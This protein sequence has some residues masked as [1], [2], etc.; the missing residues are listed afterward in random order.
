MH[1]QLSDREIIS[2]STAERCLIARERPRRLPPAKHWLRYQFGQLMQAIR[3]SQDRLDE[4]LADFRAEI[5]H[6]QEEAAAKA[7]QRSRHE[8]PYTFRKKGHEEQYR[9]NSRLAETISEGQTELAS[10]GTSTGTAVE[11]AQKA[12]EKGL[13]LIRER[14]KLIRIADRSDL[15]WGVVA[16]Y[17]A[18]ELAEDSEDEKRLEKAE[19]AAERKALKRKRTKMVPSRP[20]PSA[21]NPGRSIGAGGGVGAGTAQPV[22]Q[23][24]RRTAATLGQQPTRPLGP[25][26]ACGEMGHLRHRCPHTAAAAA[27][28]RKWY[29]PPCMHS[30]CSSELHVDG[31]ADGNQFIPDKISIEAEVLKDHGIEIPDGPVIGD[32][33][34]ACPVIP[35]D[36]SGD[37]GDREEGAG[38]NLCVEF[39]QSWELEN[40]DPQSQPVPITVKGRLRESIQFWEEQLQAPDAV[41]NTIKSGYVLPLKSEPTPFRGNNHASAYANFG[42]VQQS[43]EELVASLCVLEVSD[44]PYI[45]SPLSVV[46]SST[47]KRRLVVNLRHL[48]R[49]LWKQHFKYEDLRVAILLFQKGDFMFSFDL[50]SGYH[51][52]DIADIHTKYLGFSWAGKYYVFTVLPFG[53]A[54]A[55]Y[56]FTKLLRPLTRFWRAK[57]LRILIY[58]DDGI[59]AVTGCQAAQ[60][61]S[62]LVQTTL[63]QAGFVAHPTKS[64]W[65]PVQR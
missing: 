15:G 40:Q 13:E 11:R 2:D 49:F 59:C 39:S 51:H 18:D 24:Q 37:G 8:K 52:V 22:V 58:L 27:A 5:R 14:Q 33:G 64:V 10:A 38:D 32:D 6:S 3:G 46:E 7:I 42:F 25:C 28:D 43:V 1:E 53:L 31:G 26:F 4:K 35:D 56:I 44:P 20:R 65:Q 36:G 62:Q 30:T 63:Q 23:M 17:T 16:E 29:P 45:C 61:A 57:G 48:N 55:C 41:L 21:A 60:E 47:G 19:K 54:S 12:L 34:S 9:F 50:K